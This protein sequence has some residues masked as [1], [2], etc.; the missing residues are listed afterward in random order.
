VCGQNQLPRAFRSSTS[1]SIVTRRQET[2]LGAVY[3]GLTAVPTT[4]VILSV[5]NSSFASRDDATLPGHKV[6]QVLGLG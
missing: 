4:K 2:P 3:A 1:L 6:T 5:S